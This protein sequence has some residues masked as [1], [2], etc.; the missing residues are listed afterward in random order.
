M[1]VLIIEDNHA[2]IESLT[3]CF[4]LR[5]DVTTIISA[6]EGEKGVELARL[7]FPDIIILDLGLPD[8]DGFD[9]LRQIRSFSDV[10]IVILTARYEETD[11][12]K[13]LKLG[14]NDY[15]TKPFMLTDFLARV[16]AVLC[17]SCTPEKRKEGEK[18]PEDGKL[19]IDF[20]TGEVSIGNRII[21]LTPTEY[22][23]LCEL[24]INQGRVLSNEILLEKVW[25][26]D[27]A[28]KTEHIGTYICNL[29]KKLEEDS[30][31]PMIILSEPGIGYKFI[32]SWQEKIR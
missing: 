24:A 15:I 9:V 10:P 26:Q 17:R 4:E 23:L 11:K 5:W 7:E 29:E 30:D 31:N 6:T 3:I 16:K 13:G 12:V 18:T 21:K 22:K 28:I 2:V 14:A 32:G 1:K 8:I 25:G 20:I 27:Y 19:K